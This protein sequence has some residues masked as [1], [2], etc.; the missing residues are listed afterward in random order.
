MEE[1]LKDIYGRK[2][3]VIKKE[4]GKMYIYDVLGRRLGYY[5]GTYTYNI[6][7][8]RIGY[9]NLLVLFIKDEIQL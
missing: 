6:Q 2:V 9:G 5:D 1:V 7:G 8:R 4:N 3:G